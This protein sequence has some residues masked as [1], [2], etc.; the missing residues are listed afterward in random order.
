VRAFS[1]VFALLLDGSVRTGWRMI[2]GLPLAAV[3]HLAFNIAPTVVGCVQDIF[4]FG[5][6]TK[7]SPEETYLK[8]GLSRIALGYRLRRAFALAIRSAI[9]GDI[10]FGA[11]WFG[12]HAT[13]WTPNGFEG[14]TSGQK[15]VLLRPARLAAP[16]APEVAVERNVTAAAA[17]APS[18]VVSLAEAR[19]TL[20]PRMPSLRPARLSAA[21]R[22]V[23]A[24]E[25]RVAVA[26]AEGA[27]PQRS[28][29]SA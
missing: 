12:W 21:P 23:P 22:A 25:I 11:F 29:R 16:L 9:E 15:R 18:N 27:N 2:L 10:P 28:A 1:T 8:S 17:P 24:S 14:W 7:F 5:V 6:N 4:L 13:K 26:A 20:R 19:K 3:Y